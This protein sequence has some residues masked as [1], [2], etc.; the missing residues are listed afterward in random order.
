[1]AIWTSHIVTSI[2]TFPVPFFKFAQ[3]HLSSPWRLMAPLSPEMDTRWRWTV[4]LLPWNN[5]VQTEWGRGVPVKPQNRFW[6]FHCLTEIRTAHH[7]V[8]SPVI[9]QTTPTPQSSQDINNNYE[10]QCLRNYLNA[11]TVVRCACGHM[12]THSHKACY[13]RRNAA[14]SSRR[15]KAPWLLN[16]LHLS[17]KCTLTYVVI[18]LLLTET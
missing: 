12:Q 2:P 18:F 16:S 13:L 5:P 11:F 3:F 10:P 9:I 14:H 6:N 15:N 8:R 4:A 7:P 1:M 17:L